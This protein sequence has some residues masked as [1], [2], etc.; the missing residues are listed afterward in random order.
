MNRSRKDCPLEALDV[1]EQRPVRHELHEPFHHISLVFNSLI[2][3]G[4]PLD[5]VY[6]TQNMIMGYITLKGRSAYLLQFMYT[7]AAHLFVCLQKL[8]QRSCI[9]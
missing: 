2:I 5:L 7:S 4:Y 8:S 3:D 9:E 6:A 1:W